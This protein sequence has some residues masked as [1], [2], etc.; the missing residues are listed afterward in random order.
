MLTATYLCYA[1][2][3]QR[4]PKKILPHKVDDSH[5]HWLGRGG[6]AVRQGV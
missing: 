3:A 5:H 1:N 2:E 6:L 4:Y